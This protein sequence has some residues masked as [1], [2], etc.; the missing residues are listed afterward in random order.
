M[1]PTRADKTTHEPTPQD[2]CDLIVEKGY[3]SREVLKGLDESPWKTRIAAASTEQRLLTLAW[4]RGGARAAFYGNR[5]RL[6]SGVGR[7]AMRKR[8][9]IVERS[10]ERGVMCRTWLRGPENVHKRYLVHVAGYNLGVLVRTP[11]VI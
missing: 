9:E 8:G 3:H 7:E 2:S 6:K 10:F 5:S 1:R 4:R 11:F